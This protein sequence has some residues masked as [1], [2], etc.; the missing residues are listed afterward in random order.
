MF[1]TLA[2]SICILFSIIPA[3]YS[4][5]VKDTDSEISTQELC[6]RLYGL[7]GS[8]C[9]NDCESHAQKCTVH[10]KDHSKLSCRGLGYGSD[11]D[12]CQDEVFQKC[13]SKCKY[14]LLT[15]KSLCDDK[16]SQCLNYNSSL[17]S[18][19]T[20]PFNCAE[21]EVQLEFPICDCVADSVSKISGQIYFTDKNLISI[22]NLLLSDEKSEKFG[23]PSVHYDLYTGSAIYEGYTDIDG[24]FTIKFLEPLATNKK[25]NLTFRIILEDEARNFF[26]GVADSRQLPPDN[27]FWSGNPLAF[28]FSFVVDAKDLDFLNNMEIELNDEQKYMLE[29]AKIYRNTYQATE[30]S[31]DALGISMEKNPLPMPVLIIPEEEACYFTTPYGVALGE[32]AA[33]FDMPDSP[34]NREWHEFCHRLEY[35]SYPRYARINPNSESIGWNSDSDSAVLFEALAITCP[36]FLKQYSDTSY[37]P[38]YPIG[39]AYVNLEFNHRFDDDTCARL[40][41]SIILASV[42]WD[43]VDPIDKKDGDNIYIPYFEFWNFVTKKNHMFSDGSGGYISNTYELFDA[44]RQNRDFGIHYDPD[45]D[46]H[47]NLEEIFINHGFDITSIPEQKKLSSVDEHIPIL[48]K[49]N[50]QNDRYIFVNSKSD[51][52]KSVESYLTISYEFSPNQNHYDYTY[53]VKIPEGGKKVYILPPSTKEP[54]NLILHT[55][56]IGYS[57]SSNP[58]IFDSEFILERYCSSIAGPILEYDFILQYEGGSRCRR[59]M[60]CEPGNVC[61]EGVCTEQDL[62]STCASSYLI[63][64]PLGLILLNSIYTYFNRSVGRVGQYI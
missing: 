48:N 19:L 52:G 43:I 9:K 14:D 39:D 56:A 6:Q 26:V 16:Y 58:A 60:D 15:C 42:I 51:T 50:L 3:I 63:L 57:Q 62:D 55:D 59:D 4:Q 61:V 24:S 23:L 18:K 8:R 35:E 46:G 7:D 41:D 45:A 36:L 25:T 54:Y 44:L 30:L 21:G 2:L 37:P 20:C 11:K 5:N 33:S 49:V 28:N 12:K 1:Y 40:S 13:E 10:C 29:A 31:R 22:S 38:L 64:I 34:L 27:K 32:S 17:V 47:S 53:S